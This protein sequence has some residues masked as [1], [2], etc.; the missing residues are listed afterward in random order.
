LDDLSIF[1]KDRALF[2]QRMLKD[3]PRVIELTIMESH[4]YSNVHGLSGRME[5]FIALLSV[6]ITHKDSTQSTWI[7]F[8]MLVW[9]HL[10]ISNTSKDTWFE[11]WCRWHGEESGQCLKWSFILKSTV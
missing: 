3:S 5:I 11:I 2:L 7:K 9:I 1:Y 10:N 6:S 4:I 8:S